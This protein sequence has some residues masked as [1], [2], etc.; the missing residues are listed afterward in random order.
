MCAAEA[1]ESLRSMVD[2][3]YQS[4]KDPAEAQR[5]VLSELLRSY[6]E[7]DY[8]K[9]RA[10]Q[11]KDNTELFR[12]SFPTINYEALNPYLKQVRDGRYKAILPEPAVHWVMTRGS[13]GASKVLPVTQTHLDQILFCGAR[14]LVNHA[15]RTKD[16]ELFTGRILNLNFPSAVH[17]MTVDGK[18]VSYGYSS[19]TYARVNPMLSEVSLIPRQEDID[20][21]GSGITRRAWEE[22]FELAYQ[23]ALSEHVVSAIGVTPVISAFG[24]Y[25]KKKHGK[26]PREIWSVH[27]LFCTSVSSIPFRYGPVLRE[28]FG[29]VPIVEIYSATEGVFGQQLDDLPYVSPNYDKYFLEVQAANGMKML[30]ELKRGEWGKLIVSSCLFPRYDIGDLIES[31]G[32]GYFRVFGRDR[33]WTRFEHRMFRAFFGWST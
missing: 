29:D 4:L 30:H 6:A 9:T 27:A 26:A 20:A 23:R 28:L 2:P 21:L 31:A 14:A 5:R 33:F 19:G 8:G 10:V 17:E 3:W 22:R 11:S 32:N 15:I 24:R 13:T 25:V 16:A 18:S 7:T 12:C 1:L